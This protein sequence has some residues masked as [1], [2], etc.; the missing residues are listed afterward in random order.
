MKPGSLGILSAIISS[1]CCIGPLL[2]VFLG[3]TSLGIGAIFSRYHWGFIGLALLV[4]TGAYYLYFREKRRCA[5]AQCE[6][7]RKRI[8]QIILG[9]AT[10][11]VLFFVGANLYVYSA[12]K[13]SAKTTVVYTP[14]Q[15][16][17]TNFS[18]DGL[19]CFTCELTVKKSLKS[20]PGVYNVEASVK[21]KQVVV[22]H[23]PNQTN[24]DKLASTIEQIG[25]RVVP[26]R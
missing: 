7:Q 15:A 5:E 11:A 26:T 3:L 17:T 12:E 2:L 24:T 21:N 20:L 16:V 22:Q 18:V 13:S 9:F 6:M 10:L 23:D 4:L 25:Y 1:L 19:S 14:S 8:S